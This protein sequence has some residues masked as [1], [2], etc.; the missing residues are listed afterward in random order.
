M[1]LPSTHDG[2]V[3]EV[4][5]KVGDKVNKGDLIAHL[6]AQVKAEPIAAERPQYLP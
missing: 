4:L 1:D 5:V 6:E 3:K 2:V